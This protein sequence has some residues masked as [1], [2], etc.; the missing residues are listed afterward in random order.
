MEVFVGSRAL[1]EESLQMWDLNKRL[2]AYLSRVKHLEEENEGLRAEVQG[3]RLSPVEGSWRARY[4]GEVAALRATLEQAFRDKASA[5]L[6]RDALRDEVQ[7]ATGRCQRERAARDEAKRMLSRSR[8]ELEEERRAQLWLREKAAQLE[9]EVRALDEAH[10]DEKAALGQEVAGGGG[11]VGS[12]QSGRRGAPTAEGCFQPAE[13]EDYAQRLSSIWKGAAETYK[14]EVWQLEAAL[15]EAKEK[16]WRAT[17]GNRQ[18]QLRLQQLEKELAGLKIRKEVLEESLAQQWQQQHGEAGQL[19]LAIESLE[20]E[21]QSLRVQIAQVLDERQQLMHLKM[22][23]SLEVATYRTLLEAESTR[24][25]IP[26]ADFKLASGLRAKEMFCFSVLSTDGKLE[27]SNGLSLDRGHLGPRD[28]WLSPAMFPKASTKPRPP[29]GQNESSAGSFTSSAPP[30]NRSPLA[31]DFQ[32][33]SAILP[34]PSTIS[35]EDALP[36]KDTLAPV[37]LPAFEQTE[38]WTATQITA[39]SQPLLHES[40]PPF[41]AAA[42]DALEESSL[43]T[44]QRLQ[45]DGD[46][47]GGRETEAGEKEGLCEEEGEGEEEE[48]EEEEE[49]EEE[50]LSNEPAGEATTQNGPYPG[51]LVTEALEIALKVVN[52]AD[53]RPDTGFL[54]GSDSPN[55]LPLDGSP[56]LEDEGRADPPTSTKLVKE[57]VEKV[58]KEHTGDTL[59]AADLMGSEDP[60]EANGS[61]SE[62]CAEQHEGETQGALATDPPTP[63]KMGLLEVEGEDRETANSVLMTGRI[64]AYQEVMPPGGEGEEPPTSCSTEQGVH[65]NEEVPECPE[66]AGALGKDVAV[67]VRVGEESWDPGA[68]SHPEEQAGAMGGYLEEAED[69]EVVSTEALHLSEDEER[70]ELWSP[71]KENEEEDLQVLEGEL[72]QAEEFVACE[73]VA[74]LSHVAAESCLEQPF[75][76]LEQAQL[77]AP[78]APLE[79]MDLALLEGE[80]GEAS[81]EPDTFPAEETPLAEENSAREGGENLEG[82]PRTVENARD[83]EG[84]KEGGEEEDITRPPREDGLENEDAAE[85]QGFSDMEPVSS[86]EMEVAL[87]GKEIPGQ[88]EIS[89]AEEQ[90]V[91]GDA[92]EEQQQQLAEEEEEEG[93][94]EEGEEIPVAAPDADGDIQEGSLVV[95]QEA[96]KA[97]REEDEEKKE[98]GIIEMEEIGPLETKNLP[99]CPEAEQDGA[100]AQAE[101]EEQAVARV[102]EVLQSQLATHLGESLA[103]PADKEVEAPPEVQGSPIDG[104]EGK[105]QADTS[106]CQS[107]SESLGSEDSLESWDSSPNASRETE[108]IE[109]C[110]ESGKAIMLEET[111]PD[112]T[113]LHLY[114]GQVLAASGEPQQTP[115]E[116]QEAAELPLVTQDGSTSLEEVQHPPA[117]EE[118]L[119]SSPTKENINKQEGA[120]EEGGC[121]IEAAP[122]QGTDDP[123][124]SEKRMTDALELIGSNGNLLEED[125]KVLREEEEV[126]KDSAQLD[127][128]SEEELA[129]EEVPQKGGEV[130]EDAQFVEQFCKEEHGQDFAWGPEEDSTSQVEWLDPSNVEENAFV[131]GDGPLELDDQGDTAAEGGHKVSPLTSVADLGEIVLEGEEGSL[132]VL[133]GDLTGPEAPACGRDE[134]LPCAQETTDLEICRREDQVLQEDVAEGD[135]SGEDRPGEAAA[136]ISRESMKDADILE[137]VEQALEFNQELIKAAEP[138]VEAEPTVTGGEEGPSLEKEEEESRA[139][140]IALPDVSD[141]QVTTEAPEISFPD[142]KDPTGSG[143]LW[144]DSNAN[145]LQQEPGVAIFTKEILNGIGVLQPGETECNGGISKEEPMKKVITTQQFLREELDEPSVVE[146]TADQRSLQVPPHEETQRIEDVEP[147]VHEKVLLGPSKGLEATDPDE[148]LFVDILQAAC[149]KGG[150]GADPGA[151]SVPP[152]FGDE[153]LRLESNQHLNF[154]MEEEEEEQRWSSEDN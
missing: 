37:N 12:L 47:R 126:A 36:A 33:A 24:L 81:Q 95:G 70:R 142:A 107:Q 150:K 50:C 18:G 79:E 130:E 154:R 44:E 2:E 73:N 29:R 76:Q 120:E 64:E 53:V 13:V 118:S 62:A 10:R 90:D 93:A 102:E 9:Q 98:A 8:K 63:Q 46:M 28:P 21:K 68:S 11:G 75:L 54:E 45:E 105:D 35:F 129:G 111:L 151:V 113:P 101:E 148:S 136:S 22:S 119:H 147:E 59:P 23:L 39:V 15:G 65:G 69:L 141:S 86:Q 26:V 74:P 61:P 92:S 91:A 140:P 5:E 127:A 66:V 55:G 49:Q 124:V 14:A 100:N 72:L 121:A 152:H 97:E 7:Q 125:S 71:S 40:L 16:L 112:H 128:E 149:V 114:E 17:E 116:S 104:S 6:A 83:A 134:D 139:A 117:E 103:P 31:R 87:Q 20:E 78:G 106:Y 42:T 52:A 131:E 60:T 88:G 108:G 27:L 67:V 1:G 41:D 109:K 77:Q 25:Q 146:K 3:L 56:S 19:Q 89:K 143:P 84:G 32:K 145:G 48:E 132:D 34:D 51:R 99:W 85:K 110:L 135:P 138:C 58:L 133:G 122:I 96:S 115:P 137:I 94:R 80:V 43:G 4:E 144:A 57:A 30:K 153:V 82:E 38:V 123:K